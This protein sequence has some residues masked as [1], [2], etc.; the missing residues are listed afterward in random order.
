[1]IDFNNE[2]ELLNRYISYRVDVMANRL[3]GHQIFLDVFAIPKY[4][5]DFIMK[6]YIQSGI[7]FCNSASEEPNDLLTFEEWKDWDK[8]NE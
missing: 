4:S 2:F 3:R 5:L 1:M 6:S 7:M 8:K